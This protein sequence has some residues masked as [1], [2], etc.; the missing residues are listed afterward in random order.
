MSWGIANRLLTILL[1]FVSRTIIIQSL[2]AGYVGLGS[3][4]TS[5]LSVLSLAELG[6]SESIIF[7]MYKPMAEGDDEAVCALLNFYRKAYRCIGGIILAIGLLLMIRIDVFISGEY[8]SEMNLRVL[9]LIYLVNAVASYFSYS[10]LSVLLT[11]SQRNDIEYKIRCVVSIV[12]D[13]LQ[14]VILLLFKDYYVY[15]LILPITTLM[16]NLIRAM[17]IKKMYPTYVCRGKVSE[18]TKMSIKKQVGGLLLGKLTVASRNSFDSII[19]SS[20]IGLT[21][22]AIYSN[23]YYV[24]NMVYG[25]LIYFG[26]SIRGGI[27]NNV[28]TKSVE[29]NY[30]DMLNISELFWWLYNICTV[31]LFCL[32]QPFMR[33][34]A[35]EELMYGF[36][37]VVLFA[38][39]FYFLCN[40]VVF[41]QYMEAKGLYWENR[42]RYI[43]EVVSNLALNIILVKV[44][45]LYGIVLSTVISVFFLT[46]IYG[47]IIGFKHYFKGCDSKKYLV[48]QVFN[49]IITAISCIASYY[50]C[51]MITVNGLFGLCLRALTAMCV[52]VLIFLV[53]KCKTQSLK[54]SKDYLFYRLKSK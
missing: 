52:S 44:L 16:H 42:K 10:Y 26:A 4:F 51:S 14:I 40:F 25:F 46:N 22:V 13:T 33:L 36:W 39:Y 54:T 35:G 17:R 18:A 8:P 28:V 50:V 5:L 1:P 29:Q 34:W 49:F 11:A 37:L 27:G 21:A 15:I 31:M 6:I 45:G 41:S 12:K 30:N 32:Y 2:G 38:A 19:L 43:F 24:M 47:V 53:C 23:Y 7:S 20:V 48:R 3:L 9:F